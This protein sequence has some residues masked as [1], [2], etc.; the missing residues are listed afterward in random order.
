[1]NRTYRIVVILAV[2]GAATGVLVLKNRA[3][4]PYCMPP[5]AQEQL[6]AGLADESPG[7]P[8]AEALP[9]FVD[10]GAGQC[11]ACKMMAP[12]MVELLRDYGDRLAVEF[13]DVWEDE[14]ASEEYNIR[15]IPTQIFYDQE[16]KELFRHEGFIGKDDI[17]SK[18]E[19]FGVNLRSSSKE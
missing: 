5:P 12:I 9:R 17:L 15:M 19:E 13:I 7:S 11:A 4:K 6:P 2:I 18:W 14:A 3:H 16:G 10:F 8:K 1:M